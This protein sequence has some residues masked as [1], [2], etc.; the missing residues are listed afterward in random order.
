M[1]PLVGV[2]T[3]L[4]LL[5]VGAILLQSR[6]SGLGSTFG[7]GDSYITR[8]G[9]EKIFFRATILVA[10]LFLLISLATLLY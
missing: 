4:A 1:N 7:G 6:G 5:L 2:Q 9:V 3:V 8:R 10:F